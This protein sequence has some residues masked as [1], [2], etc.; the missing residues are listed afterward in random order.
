MLDESSLPLPASSPDGAP[1]I[2]PDSDAAPASL[3][4]TPDQLDQ[5]GLADCA[6]GE[7]YNVQL[8]CTTAGESS[9]D[10]APQFEAVGPATPDDGSEPGGAADEGASAEPVPPIDEPPDDGDAESKIL[11]YSRKK[12]APREGLPDT[13]KM[14]E[15]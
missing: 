10:G 1:P 15:I 3:N 4:L 12:K 13:K 7:V 14:R 9:P 5:L 2:S 8:K 6:S 11:G